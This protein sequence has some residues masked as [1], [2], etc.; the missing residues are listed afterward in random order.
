MPGHSTEIANE[1]IRRAQAQGIPLTQMQI[2]KLVYLAHGWTLA[3]FDKP[4]VSDPVQAWDYGPVYPMLYWALK[5]YGSNAVARQ[6]N[7]G[8]FDRSPDKANTPALC[9]L[10]Q[11]E[12]IIIDKIFETYG[13]YHAFQLSALTHDKDSPWTK[14]TEN[15]GVIP[16]DMIKKY[17]VELGRGERNN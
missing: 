15:N 7:Y 5:R 6:I 9:A 3:T 8:D 1:F 17:F 2:Q 12:Q 10:T 16:D 11:E 14:I 4:L 13:R